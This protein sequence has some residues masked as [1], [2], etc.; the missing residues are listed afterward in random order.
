MDR[1]GTKGGD[2]ALNKEIPLGRQGKVSK[3]DFQSL[4]CQCAGADLG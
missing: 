3:L 2:E 1:L 4:V